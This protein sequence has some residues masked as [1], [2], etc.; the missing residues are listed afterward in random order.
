ME[1]ELTRRL[2]ITKLFKQYDT[3]QSN[4]LEPDQVRKLLTDLDS[5]TPPDT[6]PAEEELKFIAWK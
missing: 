2:E 3:N 4:K 6:P 5:S 1:E